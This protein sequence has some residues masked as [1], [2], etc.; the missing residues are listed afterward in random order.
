MTKHRIFLIAVLLTAGC[1]SRTVIVPTGKITPPWRI[2]VY[3]TD[4]VPF[5]YEEIALV[6]TIACI[7]ADVEKATSRFQKAVDQLGADAVLNFRLEYDISVGGF[8]VVVSDA[9]YVRI[10]GVAVKIKRP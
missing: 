8:M 7:E 9:E 6:S 1:H 4:N 2:P 10:T 3:A 5:E